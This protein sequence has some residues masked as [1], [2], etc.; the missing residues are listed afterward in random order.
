MADWIPTSRPKPGHRSSWNATPNAEELA[1]KRR[2]EKMFDELKVYRDR[3]LQDPTNLQT[4]YQ[5]G[6]R[7]FRAELLDDA[8]PLFQ[9]A[10]NDPK[11][12]TMCN[13]YIGRCFYQKAYYSQSIDI[14]QE[15]IETHETPDD[16]L[17]KDLHYWLGRTYE[18]DGKSEDALKIYGQI[19]QHRDV[20]KRM[21][22]LQEQNIV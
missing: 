5:Y 9:E 19:I 14:L 2:R 8:I 4:R 6:V 20:R 15:A 1:S 22:A 12:R 16:E 17:G 11:T 3:A 13:L 18:S 10:R 21:D 7:L